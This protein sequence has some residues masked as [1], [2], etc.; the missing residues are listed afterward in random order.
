MSRTRS[1]TLLEVLI[2]VAILGVSLA[3]VLSIFGG[4][5]SRILR[6]ER[7]WARQ[8]LLTQA[9]EIFLLAGP[10]AEIVDGLFPR[11]FSARCTLQ[12]VTDLP[13]YAQEVDTGWIL[14]EYHI[15][16]IGGQG[17]IIDELKVEK[18]I[19]EDDL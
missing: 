17:E 9:T 8:H 15:S 14:G 13:A 4:A 2:A 16:L 7:T 12:P 1:F 11:N 19:L 18:M 10:N 3:L 6:A 5:R